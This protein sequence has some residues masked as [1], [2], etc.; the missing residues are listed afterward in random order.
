MIVLS[1]D[2][3]SLISTTAINGVICRLDKF[4][5]DVKASAEDRAAHARER[6]RN[7]FMVN[8]LLVL[9]IRSWNVVVPIKRLLSSRLVCAICL[10]VVGLEVD[11]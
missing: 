4:D 11:T 9:M 8:D 3:S 6:E 7:L 1:K 10:F 5:V 2:P